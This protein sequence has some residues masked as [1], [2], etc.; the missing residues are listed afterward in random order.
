MLLTYVCACVC[1][2]MCVCVCAC[3]HIYL[4][5]KI[6]PVLLHKML[7]SF[8]EDSLVSLIKNTKYG[9]KEKYNIVEK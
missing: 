2:F 5:H 8:W 4:A 7:C 1:V 6:S 3:V 9:N